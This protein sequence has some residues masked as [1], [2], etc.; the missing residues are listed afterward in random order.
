M[1]RLKV[2]LQVAS[3]FAIILVVFSCAINPVT[4]KRQIM[5]MSEAQEVAMGQEYDPQVIA[6][7]GIYDNAALQNFV[8]S[9]GIELGKISHRPNLQ[10]YVKVL[11]SPVVNAFAVPGGYIYLTRGILAQL[12]NEAELIG[13]IG[14]EMG[15]ITARHSVSQQSKQQLGQLLLIGGMIASEK[16][17]QYAEYALQGMQLLFLK[18]SRDDEREADRLGVQYSSL[19]SYDA[20]KMADFFQVLNKMNMASSEGGVPT[21]LSTH[22]D[23]GDRYNTVHQLATQW[24]D[25]LK[26]ASWKVNANSYLQLV[27]GIVYGEDPRQGYVEGNIFYHPELKFRFTFPTGWK[28]EN[29]PTQVNMAPQ[30]GKALMIFT[31][32]SQKSLQ[33]AAQATIKELNL[34]LVESRN[35]TVN[36]MPGIT[37]I[38]K[39]VSQDQTTGQKQTLMVLSY[40]ID[41]NSTFYVFHGVT[42]EADFNSYLKVFESNMM[43]FS[44]LTDASKINVKPKRVLIKSVQRAGTLAD[45]FNY[46]QVPEKMRAE[47]ALLNNMELTDKVTTGKLIKII[48]E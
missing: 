37:T 1:K 28:L 12:N 30:D 36:G 48:G 35:T 32:S 8:Q 40:F 38:S 11:D 3:F 2:F 27:N 34:T 22:P 33:E 13:V 26:L 9:K 5:L 17:A 24:Q 10:Y 45:A 4:G 46:Y 41:Y 44:K 20:H 18:F 25:S 47:L 16:F 43:S 19:I 7:F 14:H 42:S 31:L 15:H 6:T 39:Q 21:F 29:L 23:P